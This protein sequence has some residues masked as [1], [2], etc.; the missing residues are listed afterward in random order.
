MLLIFKLL[1]V[2]ASF[3]DGGSY[4]SR[5]STINRVPQDGVTYVYRCRGNRCDLIATTPGLP[6]YRPP[7]YR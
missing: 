6:S 3:Y 5:P 4:N 1:M 7:D 2:A